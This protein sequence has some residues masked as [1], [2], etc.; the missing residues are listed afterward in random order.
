MDIPYSQTYRDYMYVQLN[1]KTY[2]YEQLHYIILKKTV[3][4][5]SSMFFIF[6]TDFRTKKPGG[7]IARHLLISRPPLGIPVQVVDEQL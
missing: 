3:N 7:K 2:L 4:L 5:I 1:S 6:L